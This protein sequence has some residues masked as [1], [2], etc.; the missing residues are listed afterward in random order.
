MN[1]DMSDD[2]AQPMRRRTI[3][4]AIPVMVITLCL[5]AQPGF[6]ANKSANVTGVGGSAFPAGTVFNGIT[7]TSYRFGV[8]VLIASDGTATGDFEVTLLGTYGGQPWTGSAVCKATA[9]SVNSSGAFTFSGTTYIDMGGASPPSSA[10]F[11]STGRDK[12][13]TLSLTVGS[14]TWQVATGANGSITTTLY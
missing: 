6:A 7:L 3:W 9:G 13:N 4:P 5:L 10:T 8:G 2:G 12:Q 11:S 14:T 1:E